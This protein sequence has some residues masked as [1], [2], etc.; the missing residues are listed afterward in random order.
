MNHFRPSVLSAR[1]PARPR[2]SRSRWIGLAVAVSL[3][4]HALALGLFTVVARH[5][6]KTPPEQ[7]AIQLL[8]VERK[9]AEASPG[10]PPAPPPQPPVKPQPERKPRKTAPSP[11]PP[12]P[13]RQ[14]ANAPPSSAERKTET[15]PP[16]QPPVAQKTE[17][18]APPAPPVPQTNGEPAPQP[19][20][21]QPEPPQAEPPQR[22]PSQSEPPKAEA[23]KPEPAKPQPPPSPPVKTASPAPPVKPAPPTPQEA[24]VFNLSGTDS[25]TN[26]KV[27]GGNIVPASPDDRFRNR[28]PPYP[29]DAARRGE[30]GTVTLLIHVS[31]DGTTAGVDVI[32][33]SGYASLDQAAITA[34]RKWHFLPALRNA[35][36][37]PFDMPFRFVF[38]DN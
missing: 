6:V 32:E 35:Q 25:D 26:A 20:P 10:S 13:A 27:M 34:V 38:R 12:P 36:P 16:P 7:G 9:G 8:M 17:K 19:P 31:A 1:R 23:P 5:P 2:P 29:E 4:L 14:A 22:A 11:Q 18:P 3:L 15:P 21:P 28:P 30:H 24:P 37:V 33:S